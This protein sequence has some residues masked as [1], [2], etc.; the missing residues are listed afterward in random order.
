MFKNE[1]ENI[2]RITLATYSNRQKSEVI[3]HS[4]ELKVNITKT[5][6][7]KHFHEPGNV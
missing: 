7:G 6:F 1:M 3:P 4:E 5:C 2:L